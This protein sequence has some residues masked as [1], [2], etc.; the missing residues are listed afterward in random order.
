M[1]RGEDTLVVTRELLEGGAAGGGA[2]G[3]AAGGADDAGPAPGDFEVDVGNLVASDPAPCDARAFTSAEAAARSCCEQGA[4]ALQA[5]FATLVELPSRADDKADGR[6]VLLPPPVTPLPRHKPLPLERA[7]TKW[8]KFAETKGIK[9][10]KRSKL[11]WDETAGEWRRRFGYGRVGSD[12]ADVPILEARPGEDP[13]EDP[14]A[15]VRNEKKARVKANEKRRVA[16]VKASLKE[17]GVTARS[18]ARGGGDRGRPGLDD[19]PAGLASSVALPF[20]KGLKGQGIAAPK[21]KSKANIRLAAATAASATASMGKFDKVSS[22]E[23]ESTKYA[24]TRRPKRLA[25]VGK[26]AA[27]KEGALLSKVMGRVVDAR[28]RA[29]FVDVD[30]AARHFQKQGDDARAA[31]NAARA[32]DGL[33]NRQ[34]R[35]GLAPG[36]DERSVKKSKKAKLG[37]LGKKA[38]AGKGKGKK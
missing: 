15:R 20:E 14:F 5:L 34:R 28:E 18:A 37:G 6:L 26:E 24:N 16:N 32:A 19:I 25:V 12:E 29:A 10:R 35:K 11:V 2:G 17:H 13:D 30:K 33:T 4:R 23:R 1:A 21:T 8:E 22:L 27:E 7:K 38:K 36:E 9:K 3:G 31:A